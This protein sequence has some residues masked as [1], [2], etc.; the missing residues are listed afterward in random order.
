M[1]PPFFRTGQEKRGMEKP[2]REAFVA[3]PSFCLRD[4]TT[5]RPLHLRHRPKRRILRNVVR[6][7]SCDLRVLLLRRPLAKPFP[8]RFSRPVFSYRYHKTSCSHKSNG[9]H[10]K[11]S[12]PYVFPAVFPVSQGDSGGGERHADQNPDALH[13]SF[14]DD[15]RAVRIAEGRNILQEFS[16]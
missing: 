8:A 1:N 15:V 7:Q 11:N 4:L 16:L 12:L 10:E 9:I 13:R 3:F 14:A 5:V 2:F 6:V